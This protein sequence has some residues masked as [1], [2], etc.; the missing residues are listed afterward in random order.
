MKRAIFAEFERE[1]GL[2]YKPNQIIVSSGGK[3]VLYNA[4]MAT[5]DPGDEVV[6]PAPYWVRYPEMV[7]LSDGETVPVAC[8]ASS[9]FKLRPEDLEKAITARTKW[10][11]LYSPSNPTGAAY[12]RAELQAIAEVL[13][14]HEHVWVM[15][16]DMYEHVVYDDFHRDDRAGRAETV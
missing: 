7:A 8:S 5:L 12:T 13:V 1:N 3:Q 16:D 9:G 2:N 11:I 14:K 15:T 6:I 10:M 4:M